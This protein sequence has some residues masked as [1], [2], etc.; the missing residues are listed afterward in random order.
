MQWVLLSE[1]ENK[2]M[3]LSTFMHKPKIAKPKATTVSPFGNGD[4][5]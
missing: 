4:H 2:D 5:I 1:R 3:T